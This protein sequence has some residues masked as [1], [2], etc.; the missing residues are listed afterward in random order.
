MAS[1][2]QRNI[3]QLGQKFL[4]NN[5]Y[6]DVDYRGFIGAT[7]DPT[8][9]SGQVLIN[10]LKIWIQSSKGDYYRR[11]SMGGFFDTMQ[12]YTLNEDGAAKM[13]VDLKAAIGANFP[14]ISILEL[15][16]APNYNQRSWALQLIVKDN[17]T[18]TIAPVVTSVDAI[19]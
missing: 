6:L 5:N 15:L 10:D 11:Y 4:K 3:V 2:I 9:Q 1:I 7:V 18:G 12:R 8:L 16:V 19:T 14:T 13:T 17:L